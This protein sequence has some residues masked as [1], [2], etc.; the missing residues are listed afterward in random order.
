ML[1]WGK[2]INYTK[3]GSYIKPAFQ[4]K[5]TLFYVHVIKWFSEIKKVNPAGI[6]PVTFQ[7]HVWF[8]QWVS[9]RWSV[10]GRESGSP[11]PGFS[12]GSD[13]RTI[14]ENF[15]IAYLNAELRQLEITVSN[16]E[17]AR[18][19]TSRVEAWKCGEPV[20]IFLKEVI[21]LRSEAVTIRVEDGQVVQNA[22]LALTQLEGR[23]SL[24]GEN[25]A[26]SS[27]LMPTRTGGATAPT[28]SGI[29]WEA[30]V[31][32]LPYGQLQEGERLRT[33]SSDLNALSPVNCVSQAEV[34]VHNAMPGKVRRRTHSSR[35][36]VVSR[37]SSRRNFANARSDID[38]V[39]REAEEQ[40]QNEVTLRDS[41]V[42]AQLLAQSERAQAAKTAKAAKA[43]VD[44]AQVQAQAAQ[45]TVA[46]A[47]AAQ[48]QAAVARAQSLA[49]EASDAVT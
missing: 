12:Q 33:S 2:T 4:L 27:V 41:T 45:A 9:L 40:I 11:A 14:S 28:G 49:D 5:L 48:A 39:A 8:E 44:Q 1:V 42:A 17:S 37:V 25:V 47:Q 29:F 36:S 35:S 38:R 19:N 30:A 7:Q 13:H 6:E 22:E 15:A 32:D 46:Q 3:A 23:L 24:R 21:G 34:M 10:C 18:E 26:M 16:F 43:A 31:N 20:E